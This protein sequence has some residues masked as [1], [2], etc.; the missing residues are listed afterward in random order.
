MSDSAA[1]GL[2]DV[3]RA[4][5]ADVAS[6]GFDADIPVAGTVVLVREGAGGPEVLMI[7]RP[8]RGSF[9]GAWVFPG[10]KIEPGDQVAGAAEVDDARRAAARETVE[11]VGVVVRAET[12]VE[13]S[14]WEPPQG[15]PKRIRTWFYL[16]QVREP[17]QSAG[18]ADLALSA[19][20]VVAAQWARPADVLAGHARG[21][22]MLYPPTWVTLNGLAGFADCDTLITA[23]R[24]GGIRRFATVVRRDEAGPVFLWQPDAAADVAVGLDARGPRNRLHTGALPWRYARSDD[25]SS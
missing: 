16:G 12:L 18:A 24:A 10:G 2:Q 25:A 22:L 7:E 14:C 15:I 13:F 11:E 19:D 1:R 17:A 20:E 9:A 6:D 21:E 3:V 23:A 4:A 5:L 8:A